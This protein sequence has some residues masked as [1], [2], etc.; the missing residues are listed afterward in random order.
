MK[1]SVVVADK[2]VGPRTMTNIRKGTAVEYQSTQSYAAGTSRE[3]REGKLTRKIEHQT[4]KVPSLAYLALAGCS[5]L[6]SLGLATSQ[7]RKG[8]A[9]FVAI[10]VPSLLVIGL[11]N[12]VVKLESELQPEPAALH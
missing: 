11:Y 9:N 1:I 6:L 12:K 3:P 2:I 4:G 5:V 10:W 8:W 7:R